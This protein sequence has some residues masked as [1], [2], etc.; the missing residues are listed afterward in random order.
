MK[1]IALL[2]TQ[3][4]GSLAKAAL[5]TVSAAKQLGVP[6]AIGILGKGAKAACDTV[7][8][9]G[10]DVFFAVEGDA[11]EQPRYATDVAAEVA[12]VQA[13]GADVVLEAQT[14]RFARSLPGAAYRLGA[15]TDTH[16]VSLALDG[17]KITAQRWYYRQRFSRPSPARHVRWSCWS[18][19]VCTNR[20][21]VRLPP[22]P[23]RTWQLR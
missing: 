7:A 11:F 2:H 17:E 9:S 13:A 23:C 14:S 18:I 3:S 15:Q 5:E 22:R 4:D 8:A 19:P 10:A 1:L 16:I 21:R 12:L 20:T 6:F